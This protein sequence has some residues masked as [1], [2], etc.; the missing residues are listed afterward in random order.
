MDH[1]SD[2]FSFG[3]ILYEMLTGV[4]PFRRPLRAETVSAILNQDPSPILSYVEDCPELL[5][6]TVRKML[7]KDTGGRYQ[8][9]HEVRTDLAELSD[10]ITRSTAPMLP[11]KKKPNWVPVVLGLVG[12]VLAVFIVY[13]SWTILRQPVQPVERVGK[14]IAVLPLDN[15]SADPENAYF[16][17]GITEDITTELSKIGDLKVIART[18][19][20]RYKG[21]DKSLKEI[22]EELGVATLLEGSVRK[23]DDRVRIVVQLIDVKTEGH[24]WAETYDRDL[25]DIFEIQSDVARAIATALRGELSQEEER[26]LARKPTNKIEAYDLVL[27]AR[28]FRFRLGDSA[29]AISCYQEAIEIDPN[30]AIAYAELADNWILKAAWGLL[31]GQE[32]SQLQDQAEGMIEKAF[33][34]D[35]TLAEPYV[36][37]GLL[38]E[39]QF[40]W[41]LAE[42]AFRTGIDLNPGHWNAQFEYANF[43][44]RLGRYDEAVRAAELAHAIDPLAELSN[45]LLTHMYLNAGQSD[46]ALE[47][48]KKMVELFPNWYRGYVALADVYIEKGWLDQAFIVAN[49][50]RDR[51]NRPKSTPWFNGI[52][53]YLYALT[54]SEAEAL[55][56]LQN[57]NELAE[58]SHLLGNMQMARIQM[59]LGNKTEA[60]N[61]LQKSGIRIVGGPVK[62]IAHDPLWDPLRNDLHFQALVQTLQLPE[63]ANPN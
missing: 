27:Q 42:K 46:A 7:A 56:C 25:T 40:Q 63:D 44:T 33:E 41:L 8:S 26:L 43:L 6:H 58:K 13:W 21:S 4:H 11:I 10:E 48:A 1:R 61:W 60:L 24:L 50:A 62:G 29:E 3:I 30:Y 17:D 45:V 36:S 18:S 28:H 19:A 39:H 59:A 57:L 20:F 35:S 31:P 32:Q 15:L 54:G 53:G 16:A 47:V 37:L 14:S 9:A 23:T 38:R 34:L 2:L 52:L 51:F 49:D 55:D 12:L 5:Q 22:A